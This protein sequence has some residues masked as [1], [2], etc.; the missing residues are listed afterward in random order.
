MDIVYPDTPRYFDAADFRAARHREL[1]LLQPAYSVQLNIRYSRV[2]M[3][4]LRAT[5]ES[6]CCDGNHLCDYKTRAC[7]RG[8]NDLITLANGRCLESMSK[9][10]WF[11][12]FFTDIADR[13]P[14]RPWT[15]AGD[16]LMYRYFRGLHDFTSTSNK[17]R[18]LTYVEYDDQ[19]AAFHR[20]EN[21]EEDN[22]SDS[23]RERRR[24]IDEEI[25]R[26]RGFIFQAMARQ[27]WFSNFLRK[28]MNLILKSSASQSSFSS[29][30]RRT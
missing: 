16:L 22:L 6:G 23:E 14:L 20:R 9:N 27:L 29:L 5:Q 4:H 7:T 1:R 13:R 28:H 18:Y 26:A 19:E 25:S 21:G 3:W 8:L 30:P 24:L 11:L 15:E 12:K 2:D 10:K 17:G